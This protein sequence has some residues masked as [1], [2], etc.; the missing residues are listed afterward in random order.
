MEKIYDFKKEIAKSQCIPLRPLFQSSFISLYPAFSSPVL[1]DL[2]TQIWETD[3][4]ISVTVEGKNNLQITFESL[5]SEKVRRI[6][7]EVEKIRITNL[8]RDRLQLTHSEKS[9][10]G[11][12]GWSLKIIK[13]NILRKLTMGIN[14]LENQ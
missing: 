5:F 13:T 14:R 2:W 1:P 12:M 6:L 4:S 10:S 7:I 9:K 11:R 3:W 8:S